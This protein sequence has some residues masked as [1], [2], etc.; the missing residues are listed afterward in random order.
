ME[1]ILL[2][3]LRVRTFRFGKVLVREEVH[4]E[5]GEEKPVKVWKI[6]NVGDLSSFRHCS[7]KEMMDLE[8]LIGEMSDC[9]IVQHLK[10]GMAVEYDVWPSRTAKELV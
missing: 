2:E 7:R 4:H 10:W 5:A 8:A 1:L 3:S 9:K 6:T